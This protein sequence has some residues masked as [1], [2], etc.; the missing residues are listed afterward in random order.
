M[1]P[2]GIA[3]T[4]TPEDMEYGREMARVRMRTKSRKPMGEL[5]GSLGEV[6]FA[7][8][9]GLNL[10]VIEVKRS[11]GGVDF[12]MANGA[13][14]DVKSTSG[15][16]PEILGLLVPKRIR[17]GIYALIY[18]NEPEY[19]AMSLGWQTGGWACS[20]GEERFDHYRIDQKQLRAP[21]DLY[22]MMEVP[23]EPDRI[24]T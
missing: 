21:T 18:V 24:S 4:F 11:D 12:T 1:Y 22:G 6:A 23:R 9:Y 2:D 20:F 17:A 5:E 10:P 14:V 3:Y 8:I 13:T 19:W 7:R 16:R 15:E